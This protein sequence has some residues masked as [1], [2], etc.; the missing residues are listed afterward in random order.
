MTKTHE[1]KFARVPI[2][3]IDPGTNVRVSDT[4]DLESLVA[5]IRKVG[6]LQPIT[7]VPIAG[8]ADKVECVFGHRRLA[9]ARRAGLKIVPCIARPRDS[10]A[11]RVLTQ[12]AENY[13]RRDMTPLEEALAYKEL[14]DAGMTRQQ[15]AAA[16]GKKLGGIENKLRLLQY[17]D[18]VQ[19]AVHNGQIGLVDALMIPVDMARAADGRTLRAVCARGNIAVREWIRGER[20]RHAANGHTFTK[21]RGNGVFNVDPDLADE[22]RAHCATAGVTITSF[23]ERAIRASLSRA[24][25]RTA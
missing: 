20:T 25:T 3:L 16:T 18:V 9:A 24:K 6:I 15:I 1:P 8:R 14:A 19:R 10:A 22:V 4:D 2:E 11:N 5:S 7:V 13:E 12:L 21:S 17:P 23:V